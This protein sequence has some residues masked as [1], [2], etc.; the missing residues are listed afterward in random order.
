VRW[1]TSANVLAAVLLAIWID[2]LLTPANGQDRSAQARLPG[3]PCNLGPVMES[4]RAMKSTGNVERDLAALQQL[5]DGIRS[6]LIACRGY[7]FKGTGAKLIGPLSLPTGTW[8]MNLVTDGYFIGAIKPLSGTCVA[9][10]VPGDAVYNITA[11]QAT[12][13]AG[14]V[15]GSKDCRFVLETTNVTSAWTVTFEPLK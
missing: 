11:G 2:G 5:S 7:R 10:T 4:A 3:P 12:D 14:V 9:G 1:S 8:A 15:I 13:G 6:Q